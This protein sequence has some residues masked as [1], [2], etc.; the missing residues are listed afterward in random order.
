MKAFL[1]VDL[2]NDFLPG[3]ALGVENGDQIV[4]II[5]KLQEVFS[6]VIASKD[7]HPPNHTSFASTHKRKPGEVITIDGIEQILWPDH[8]V[9]GTW[10][11]EFTP[12]LQT[13]K[14]TKVFY[15]GVDPRIDSYSAFYDNKNLRSTGLA[16]YLRDMAVDEIYIAG[17]T[18]DYCVKYSVLDASKLGF[19][20]NVILDGCRGI[21]LKPGN[22]DAAIHKIQAAGAEVINSSDA[23]LQA[24]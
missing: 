7:W 6:L 24:I 18:T 16:E 22:V 1:I 20:I 3:G 19:K 11:A 2:Q 5:N 14:I 4:P 13:E 15:K 12:L 10:G 23:L 9:Q 8:C 21:D 17:L